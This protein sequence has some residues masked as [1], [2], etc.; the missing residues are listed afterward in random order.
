MAQPNIVN[1]TSILGETYTTTLTTTSAVTVISGAADKVYKMNLINVANVDG[2]ND[3]AITITHNNGTNDVKIASTVTVPADA[4]LQVTTKDSAFYLMETHVIKAVASA[5]NDLE[6]TLSY[7][8]I[9][10]A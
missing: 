3:A 10:D 5:A 1:V 4:V 9:D 8:I 6:L 2:T 7:E